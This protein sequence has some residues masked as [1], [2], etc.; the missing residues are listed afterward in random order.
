MF[1]FGVVRGFAS[2]IQ[3]THQHQFTWFAFME[4]RTSADTDCPDEASVELGNK[5]FLGGGTLELLSREVAPGR[6][7]QVDA[8][9]GSSSST[10]SF[11][12]GA[13]PAAPGGAAAAA[14]PRGRPPGIQDA[15]L[16]V[17]FPDSSPALVRSYSIADPSNEAFTVTHEMD[18]DDYMSTIIGTLQLI[19][20]SSVVALGIYL[21]FTYPEM[22]REAPLFFY[23]VVFSLSAEVALLLLICLLMLML[24]LLCGQARA[25]YSSAVCGIFHRTMEGVIY[26]LCVGFG[27]SLL[28]LLAT[29]DPQ[30][31]TVR[32]L[33][34]RQEFVWAFIM[35][36]MVLCLLYC[37]QTIPTLYGICKFASH[38]IYMK[39]TGRD[40]LQFQRGDVPIAYARLSD[41]Y[42]SLQHMQNP[43]NYSH[44]INYNNLS[45]NN[46]EGQ[47]VAIQMREEGGEKNEALLS[48]S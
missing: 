32:Y 7:F 30:D 38:K 47:S 34:R 17:E 36:E 42:Y 5:I 1:P 27:A 13:A 35:L 12:A 33:G 11:A 9:H 39:L 21:L 24:R 22:I 14:S 16:R 23:F 40:E 10:S 45:N 2:S 28:L 3:R 31:S 46:T 20:S 26:F 44:N 19:I 43:L 41:Y 48:K 25:A 6:L 15:P 8:V 4:P 29:G 18:F 37:L